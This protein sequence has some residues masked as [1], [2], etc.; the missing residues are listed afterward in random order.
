MNKTIRIGTRSSQ[1]ALWQAKSVAKKLGKLGFETAL[2]EVSSTGDKMLDKPLHQ[3]G[4]TGLFTKTLDEAMLR[5]QIDL[6]VHSLKDVP[7]D[8][9]KGIVQAAVLK[10]GH[11]QDVLVY[12]DDLHFLDRSSAL[13]AT[14]SLRRKAQWL[15]RYASHG[16]TDLRGNVNTRLKKLAQHSWDGAIFAMAGLQRID[17]LPEKHLVLD[18]MLPAPA[19]GAIMVAGLE[20]DLFVLE[21]CQ[22]LHHKETAR[23]VCVERQFMKTL[24]GGCTAP[25]GALAKIVGGQLHFKGM[26][27]ALD[28][29]EQCVVEKSTRSQDFETFGNLCAMEL[30]NNGGAR[31]MKQIKREI[32]F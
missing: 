7:T 25:I 13:I 24:E 18:W 14:G 21:A 28:G 19:Q 23:E 30:L 11:V 17:L 32:N 8:L 27:I 20:N 5:G 31:L 12:K 10:R 6:A 16:V 22:E 4:E 1:L 15:H 9:P 3:I 29:R 26:L 2:V